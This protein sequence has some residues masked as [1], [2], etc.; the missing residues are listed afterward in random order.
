MAVALSTEAQRQ[1][2]EVVFYSKDIMTNEIVIKQDEW[3]QSLVDDCK[4]IMCEAL[5]N[6]RWALVEGYHMLGERIT[7]DNKFQRHAKGNE[8]SLKDLSRKLSISD[9]R[10]YSAIQFYKKFPDLAK[11]PEGK[12]ISW[13]KILTKYLP[14]PPRPEAPDLPDDKYTLIYADPPWRYDFSQTE[15]REIENQYPTMDVEEICSLPINTLAHN[16]CVLFLWATNPKLREALQVIQAWGFEYKTNMVWIK[17]R[18]GM[19]YYARQ[20]HELLLIATKGQPGTPDPEDRPESAIFANRR[21]HSRKPDEFYELLEQ[22]YPHAKKIELF[23]RIERSG[24][25]GW[26]N[27]Y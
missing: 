20:K 3:Y 13:N 8:S 16:D 26:G 4:A 6:S 12:N 24:W 17:D 9:R 15:S 7:N 14:E 10:L 18:I 1:P 11:L 19:G 27:E 25:T 2:K 21:E 5:F 22:M 23:S